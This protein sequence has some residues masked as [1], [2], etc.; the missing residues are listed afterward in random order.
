MNLLNIGIE[1][2]KKVVYPKYIKIFP[3]EERKE[4]KTIEDNFSKNMTRFIKI[5]ENDKFIGFFIINTIPNNKYL[6]KSSTFSY[7]VSSDGMFVSFMVI[8]FSI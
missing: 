3:K 7:I 6:L 2:F 1:E 8:L 4:L 5:C